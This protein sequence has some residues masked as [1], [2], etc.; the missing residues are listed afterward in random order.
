MLPKNKIG[1]GI[2]IQVNGISKAYRIGLEQVRHDTLGSALVSFFR[3]PLKNLKRLRELSKFN[4]FESSDVYW[5]NRDITFNVKKG[6]VLGIIGKNGAGK[7]TLLKILSKITDPTEGQILINGKVASLLEVGTGFNPELTGRENVYLNGT[8]LGMTKKEIDSKFN[9]IVEFS[10]IPKFIDTPVK[11]YSSG[12][13]VRLAFAVAAFLEP[14]ILIIDEVLAVGDAEFQ[15]KCLGKMKEIS[16]NNGRTVLFV[17]HDLAAVKSLCSRVVLLNQGKLVMDSTPE[18]A[19]DN[20]LTLGTQNF[21]CGILATSKSRGDKR[22][23]IQKIGL[24]NSNNEPIQIAY[25]GQDIKFGLSYVI[26]ELGP[27]PIVIIRFKDNLERVLFSCLSRN[28]YAGNMNINSK[29]GTIFCNIPK[30]PLLPGGYKMD[31][32]LKYGYEITFDL[33]NAFEIQ[34]EKGDFFNT[35]KLNNDLVNGLIIY[36]N[37]Q[38]D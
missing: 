19:I 35:G 23:M 20:Y 34:V 22:F 38:I 4:E 13:K 14:D 24:F 29:G 8:I 16:G 36:H 25:T 11:R 18:K 15:K 17:S 28:S 26:N 27:D 37:W 5:A 10:G 32:L 6:E 2:A 1:E 3:K 33:E 12:M 9:E 7:S 31:I 21:D 30:L